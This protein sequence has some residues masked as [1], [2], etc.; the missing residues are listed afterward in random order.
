MTTLNTKVS[1][2]ISKYMS[3]MAKRRHKLKPRPREYYVELGRKGGI[4]NKLNKEIKCTKTTQ[5]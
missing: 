5:I 2:E 1:E 4:K 3:E